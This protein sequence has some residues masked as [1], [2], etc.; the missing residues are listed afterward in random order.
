MRAARRAMSLI[1]RRPTAG[2]PEAACG[3]KQ[4]HD[5]NADEHRL[6]DFALLS[7]DIGQRAGHD[8]TPASSRR[9]CDVVLWFAGFVPSKTGARRK[10]LETLAHLPVTVVMYES[11]HRILDTL[12]DMARCSE[13]ARSCLREN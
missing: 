4:Q 1:G 5:R 7:E 10:R 6:L 8:D 13:S 2:Q 9:R 11:P 12:S 3:R